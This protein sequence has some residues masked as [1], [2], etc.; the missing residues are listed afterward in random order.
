MPTENFKQVFSPSIISNHQHIMLY[1]LAQSALGFIVADLFPAKQDMNS[2]S[3]NFI[4]AVLIV[5][6]GVGG[7]HL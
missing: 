2:V 1:Q 5:L 4:L 7:I 3:H 6:N